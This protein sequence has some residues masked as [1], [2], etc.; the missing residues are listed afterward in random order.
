MNLVLGKIGNNNED[1][2]LALDIWINKDLSEDIHLM[3]D[4]GRL[5]SRK[6]APWDF[7]G[8]MISGKKLTFESYFMPSHSIVGRKI[9]KHDPLFTWAAYHPE[10]AFLGLGNKKGESWFF[11]GTRNMD[12]FGN[13]T[14]ASYNP[15]TNNFWFKSQSGFGD[16]NHNFFS[17]ETYKIAAEYLVVPLFFHKHFSPII[18]KGTFA[19]K[20]EGRRT[21]GIHNYEVMAA[22]KINFKDAGIALGINSEY[23]KSL[24]LAPSF[25]IYKIWKVSNYS[26]VIELRYDM[27]Y[28]SLSG[29][30]VLKY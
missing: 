26:G 5:I 22:K 18:S 17:L 21:A 10:H 4:G 3:I 14:F 16:I 7:L 19:L 23:N 11:A 29:Y 25:E 30:L 6:G 13:F 12:K 28:N 8:A 27:V 2:R 15:E 9:D 24:H 1:D 20:I